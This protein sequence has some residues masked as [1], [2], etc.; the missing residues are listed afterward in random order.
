MGQPGTAT[1]LV[2]S[3]AT[4]FHGSFC[5]VRIPDLAFPLRSDYQ[6]L[7]DPAG[8]CC[9]PDPVLSRSHRDRA[10]AGRGMSAFLRIILRS[11]GPPV[12]R[13]RW[14]ASGNFKICRDVRDVHIYR[15]THTRAHKNGKEMDMVKSL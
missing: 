11:S 4:S 15:H 9:W 5:R 8:M 6:G 1:Q 13:S 10:L 7:A 2:Q 3:N 12:I 14:L